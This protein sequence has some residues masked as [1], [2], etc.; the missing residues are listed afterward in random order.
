MLDVVFQ[1]HIWP[2]ASKPHTRSPYEMSGGREG[3]LW[4]PLRLTRRARST[5]TEV[6]HA[7]HPTHSTRW[8]W[9]TQYFHW[10]GIVGI[11]RAFWA[12][13][14]GNSSIVC[15]VKVSLGGEDCI[16]RAQRE[17]SNPNLSTHLKVPGVHGRGSIVPSA[18]HEYPPGHRKHV[19]V[20]LRGLYFDQVP[21][22]HGT[23]CE[24]PSPRLK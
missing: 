11:P 1:S 12:E 3:V 20:P 5:L 22:R 16:S 10:V 17:A 23:A 15:P 18:A 2:V 13:L 9:H 19:S 21:A 8:T 14:A 4:H 6:R 7:L 24:L